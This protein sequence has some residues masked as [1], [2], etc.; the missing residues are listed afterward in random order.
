MKRRDFVAGLAS[1]VAWPI[2][3]QAQRQSKPVIGF[4]L[5][6]NA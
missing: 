5:R 2:A 4:S 3:A 1:A 6:R